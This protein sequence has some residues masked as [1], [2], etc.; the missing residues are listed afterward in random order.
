MAN[1]TRTQRRYDHRLRNLVRTTRDIH[2]AIQR[3]VPR[4]TARGWLTES[5]VPVVTVE[6]LNLDATQLQ[7]EVLQLSRRIQKLIALLRVLLVV[8]RMSGY[9]LSQARLPDGGNKRSL[10]RA[11]ERSRASLPLRSVLRAVRLSPSRYHA[12]NREDQCALDYGSSC[13]RSSPQQLTATEVGGIKGD[14][15][16]CIDGLRRSARCK[17]CGAARAPPSEAYVTTC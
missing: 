8:L 7:R 9:S 17:R 5:D 13:P 1:A 2:C 4:S 11:I 15:L 16:R 10:L 3:G 12:W 6:A 14:M